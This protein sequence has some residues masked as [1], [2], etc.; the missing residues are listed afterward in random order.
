MVKFRHKQSQCDFALS[1]G[2]GSPSKLSGL[3]V[4]VDKIIATH[5]NQDQIDKL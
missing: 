5:N 3:I 4:Y 2:H 1:I